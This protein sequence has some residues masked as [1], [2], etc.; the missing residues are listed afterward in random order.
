MPPKRKPPA[1]ALSIAGSDSGGGAGLQADQRAMEAL[2]VHAGCALTA[3][4]AQN[5]RGVQAIQPV[6]AD[7]LKTQLSAVLADLPIRA[8]KTG[9]LTGAAQIRCIARI[10]KHHPRLPLVVDPVL[11]S[12][13]GT[14]F[15][16]GT[17]LVV[18]KRE[19]L[20]LATLVTPNLP[21]LALLSGLPT[22]NRDQVLL[23]AA[24]LATD[25]GCLVLAKGGH[26]AGSSST[27]L[28][29]GPSGLL[30]CYASRRIQT[31]NTH[32]T[33]CTLSAAITAGL[34]QGQPLQEA[35]A[36]AKRLLTNSLRLHRSLRMGLGHGPALPGCRPRLR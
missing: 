32:G 8:A 12:S 3:I 33:G 14:R 4:T 1:C 18:L 21:E 2:G 9:L 26:A 17:A 36:Q 7:L 11:V 13:S 28:L 29:V 15:L 24:R 22:G 16:P 25:C 6:S 5:T 34:A 27:D 31:R 30:R 35:I 10:L 20:P 19:L 23:A